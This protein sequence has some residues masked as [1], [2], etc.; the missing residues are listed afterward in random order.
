ML[1]GRSLQNLNGFFTQDFEDLRLLSDQTQ[2][3]DSTKK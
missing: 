1:A 2:V 3:L